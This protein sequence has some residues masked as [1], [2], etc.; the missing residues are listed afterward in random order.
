MAK[1]KRFTSQSRQ[2]IIRFCA[3][4]RMSRLLNQ[5]LNQFF[6]CTIHREC[7]VIIHIPFNRPVHKQNHLACS[8]FKRIE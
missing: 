1:E 7:N 3:L 5:T 6:Y 8:K 2:H 4:S